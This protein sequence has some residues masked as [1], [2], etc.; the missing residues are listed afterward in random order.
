MAFAGLEGVHDL[1]DV[2][3]R[4]KLRFGIRG[5]VLRN[6]LFGQAGQREANLFDFVD[7]FSDID[8]VVER[9][10]H[11]PLIRQEILSSLPFAGFV[12]WDFK[13]LDE[14][15]RLRGT[16]PSMAAERIIAWF[17]PGSRRPRFTSLSEHS[18]EDELDR[19]LFE[20]DVPE[21]AIESSHG[22]DTVLAFLRLLRVS[23]QYPD[24]EISRIEERFRSRLPTEL[25]PLTPLNLARL[26]RILANIL[27]TADDLRAIER[28]LHYVDHHTSGSFRK[29]SAP[30][31]SLLSVAKGSQARTTI[32]AYRPNANAPYEYSMAVRFGP[33][34]AGSGRGQGFLLPP[35]HFFSNQEPECCGYRD[36]AAGPAVVVY[37]NWSLS[38]AEVLGA[39]ISASVSPVDLYGEEGLSEPEFP[40]PG[41]LDGYRHGGVLRFDPAFA[42][43]YTGRRGAFRAFVRRGINE[44]VR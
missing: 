16:Y 22:W 5:G 10:D 17:D 33:E 4:R 13:V 39:T 12:H 14:I 36:F 7:P 3:T 34:E 15:F 9:V 6:L 42:T 38:P 32:S 11:I 28:A 2:A 37:R 40:L 30:L 27:A 20:V 43:A 8:V 1:V 19:S 24:L 21:S 41:I 25:P 35:I 26:N 18:V 23:G 29:R 44:E 31:T